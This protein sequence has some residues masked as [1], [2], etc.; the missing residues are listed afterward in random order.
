VILWWNVS[1]I[2]RS[3][4]S[5]ITERKERERQIGEAEEKERK[6]KMKTRA[7]LVPKNST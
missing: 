5:E 4:R 7:A 3:S 2:E 6:K 1:C